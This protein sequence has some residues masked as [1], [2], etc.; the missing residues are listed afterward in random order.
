MRELEKYSLN[1]TDPPL[2]SRQETSKSRINLA[3]RM[4]YDVG[5]WKNMVGGG[6]MYKGRVFELTE[7]TY[8]ESG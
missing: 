4:L 1:R 8:P 2:S 6:S 7:K 3:S 5:N